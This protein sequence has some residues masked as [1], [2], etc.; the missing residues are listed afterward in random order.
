MGSFVAA[1]LRK[2]RP[3]KVR[4]NWHPER[5]MKSYA[6][7]ESESYGRMAMA[8]WC[9]EQ[10]H[11]AVNLQHDGVVVALARNATDAHARDALG[12]TPTRHGA[13]S[14]ACGYTQPVEVKAMAL[15]TG[16]ARPQPREDTEHMGKIGT[17]AS[18]MLPSSV[19][20]S[21]SNATTR[22]STVV[23]HS[24]TFTSNSR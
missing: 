10:G 2:H 6:F 1:W 14:A 16:L 9:E 19:P 12:G 20:A 8:K 18:I 5:T 23:M 11:A 3:E 24:G 17:D 7:Q 13:C 4:S 21:R 22:R 15:P